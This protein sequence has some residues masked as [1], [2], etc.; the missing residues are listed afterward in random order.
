MN[1]YR[2]SAMVVSLQYS[3]WLIEAFL[4]AQWMVHAVF[5]TQPDRG[6]YRIYTTE[7]V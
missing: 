7:K 5:D 6:G 1:R 4:L 3:Y 2:F